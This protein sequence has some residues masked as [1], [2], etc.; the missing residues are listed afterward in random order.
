MRARRPVAA[1]G[2]GVVKM[3]AGQPTRLEVVPALMVDQ[4]GDADARAKQCGQDRP[5]GGADE[6]VKVAH[7]DA[8]LILE[9]LKSP[10]HPRRAEDSAATEHQAPPGAA[11][12]LRAS[13]IST[14][15]ASESTR[16]CPRRS[17]SGIAS[18]PP[19]S[20]K[21]TPPS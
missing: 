13:L 11:A 21:Y 2:F 6:R 5:C 15:S 8:G 17:R 4:I 12:H 14:R 7:I 10:D 9:S 3:E 1:G 20:P 19:F 16:H 18:R